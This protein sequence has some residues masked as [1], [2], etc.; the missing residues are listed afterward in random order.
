MRNE[1][2]DQEEGLEVLEEPRSL[3]W[4]SHAFWWHLAL[5]WCLKLLLLTLLFLSWIHN[6]LNWCMFF[7]DILLNR[8]R[9]E[10]GRKETISRF[11]TDNPVYQTAVGSC[12]SLAPPS[13][14]RR[15]G[16]LH[17]EVNSYGGLGYRHPLTAQYCSHC[18][19]G[20]R[21]RP[22]GTL[23]YCYLGFKLTCRTVNEWLRC[24]QRVHSF[25]RTKRSEVG[26]WTQVHL[27]EQWGWERCASRQTLQWPSVVASFG[28]AETF[29]WPF[30]RLKK[31]LVYRVLALRSIFQSLVW[32]NGRQE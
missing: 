4:Q 23:T 13:G 12:S 10:C 31:R 27:T 24:R 19:A 5:A 18:R 7:M 1:S 17:H 21:E 28:K 8:G 6:V 29:F 25:W 2:S 30:W 22:S 15:H 16:L 20:W 32:Q 3:L 11:S 14:S 9:I 26:T